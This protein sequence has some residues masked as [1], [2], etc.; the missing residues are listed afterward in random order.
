MEN[1]VPTKWKYL[2]PNPKS[3]YKQFFVR[4]TRI[5]ARALY[6]WFA[7]PEPMPPED[8]AHEFNLPVEAV[9]E[10]IAYCESNPPELLADY[11]REQALI[12]AVAASPDGRLSPQE[13]ARIR[14][15]FS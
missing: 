1:A 5:S 10:S 13:I 12:E 3:S 9:L 2:A 15:L 8:I 7:G 14:R 4:G 6:G 11:A